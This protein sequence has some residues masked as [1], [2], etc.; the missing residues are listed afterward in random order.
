MNPVS[1][2]LRL[3]KRGRHLPQIQDMNS[4]VVFS[5]DVVALYPSI[6]AEMAKDAITKAIERSDI[7]WKDVNT[8]QLSRYVAMTRDRKEIVKLGLGEVVPQPKGTTTFRSY[9]APRDNAK[10]TD[11]D[12]EFTGDTRDPSPKETKR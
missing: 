8:K 6:L 3:R 7:K 10:N 9:S 2:K 12:S 4:L 1:H 5:M 11:G